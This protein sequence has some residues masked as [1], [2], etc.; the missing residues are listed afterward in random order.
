MTKLPMWL[1]AA[2]MVMAPPIAAIAQA[3]APKWIV[4]WGQKKCSL[5]RRADS[6][7][8][9]LQ[10]VP[11]TA[12]PELLLMR[13]SSEMVEP[14]WKERVA[15]QLQPSGA[16]VEADGA[17]AGLGDQ[18]V[19]RMTGMGPGFID[20][21]AASNG[22]RVATASGELAAVDLPGADRAIGALR[23]CIDRVLND[24][25][26]DPKALAALRRRPELVSGP[27]LRAD[28]YPPSAER[29]EVASSTVV[30]FTVGV[31][32]RVSDCTTVASSGSPALDRQTCSALEKRARFTPALGANGEAVPVTL[33]ENAVWGIQA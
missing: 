11:G 14:R 23:Q 29:A 1:V 19:A 8:L 2:A 15:I 17:H 10:I 9:T 31:D 16:S 22:I 21:F 6:L 33:V 5:L 30:R 4:N 7:T 12:D 27:W 20:Q 18:V 28:D 13:E 3:P 25:G 26:V 24:W 32:G